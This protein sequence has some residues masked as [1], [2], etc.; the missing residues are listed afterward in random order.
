[1]RDEMLIT[2]YRK[3]LEQENRE[4]KAM[5][6]PLLLRDSA[7]EIEQRGREEGIKEGKKDMAKGL[8]AE[9]V[10][11]DII[12]RSSWLPLDAVKALMN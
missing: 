7:A 4:G 5:Y 11:A 1:M 8:L 9:G 12:A 3:I 10:P 2:Q 6:I